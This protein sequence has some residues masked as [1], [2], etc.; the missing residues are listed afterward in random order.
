MADGQIFI[1][2][3]EIENLREETEID[4][5]RRDRKTK[6]TRKN[7]SRDGQILIMNFG[8][9]N[10]RE[11]IGIGGKRRDRKR[12]SLGKISLETDGF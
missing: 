11:E 9:E 2:S 1:M 3:L 6:F 10:L 5:K 8:I 4:G 7:I 12:N